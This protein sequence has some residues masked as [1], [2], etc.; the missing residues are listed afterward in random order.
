M[1]AND[2]ARAANVVAVVPFV[3]Y[4]APVGAM[5]LTL[6]GWPKDGDII[7]TP[8]GKTL[9]D[10]MSR[11]GGYWLQS[12]GIANGRGLAEAPVS[13]IT[14]DAALTER[15]TVVL[16][17]MSQGLTNAQIA[18]QLMLSESSIR[19]ETVKIYRTL[20]VHSRIEAS[21]KGKALGFI[22]R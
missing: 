17:L 15:Q 14:D 4:G 21:K 13:E 6:S 3:S 20:G 7:N 11:L 2:G 12:N 8:G 9:S 5:V 10:L 22:S 19:Q 1:A 16:S 18:Q